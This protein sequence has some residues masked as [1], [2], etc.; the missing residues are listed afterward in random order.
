MMKVPPPPDDDDDDNHPVKK[1]VSLAHICGSTISLLTF[2]Q[3]TK[4]SF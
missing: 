4:C 3:A 1:Y 2:H